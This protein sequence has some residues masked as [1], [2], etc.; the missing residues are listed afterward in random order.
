M[1]SFTACPSRIVLRSPE[2]DWQGAAAGGPLD[3]AL[4]GLMIRAKPTSHREEGRVIAQK[5]PAEMI[6]F[7]E[8]VY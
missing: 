5:T 7:M 8:A 6:G 3:A 1:G 2:L 4:L